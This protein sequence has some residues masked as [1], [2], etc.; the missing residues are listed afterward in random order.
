[1]SFLNI[2]P[3]QDCTGSRYRNVI[4]DAN[5]TVN[6]ANTTAPVIE[7]MP[8]VQLPCCTDIGIFDEVAYLIKNY[9]VPVIGIGLLVWYLFIK[10]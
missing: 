3:C 4:A 8:A 9:P 1:M 2:V 10:K 7:R 5:V 6:G